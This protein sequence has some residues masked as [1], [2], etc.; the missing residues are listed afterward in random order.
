MTIDIS[1]SY[2]STLGEY[3][4][5]QSYG[6]IQ[7][8]KTMTTA[9]LMSILTDRRAN[10]DDELPNERDKGGWW[11]DLL[12]DDNTK[13]GSRLW[14]L[15]GR[16]DRQSLNQAKEY[17]KESIQWFVDDGIWQYFSV[18]TEKGGTPYNQRLDFQIDA[19]YSNGQNVSYKFKDL[20]GS[21]LNITIE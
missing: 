7:T 17:I 3:D 14:L 12:E 21:Q 6:D 13:T 10:D 11:G 9:L 4:I 18:V 5:K 8:D 16:T 20:W 2:N 19:H 15:K 1:V